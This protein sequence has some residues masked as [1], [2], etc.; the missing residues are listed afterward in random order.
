MPE[1]ISRFEDSIRTAEIKKEM[2]LATIGKATDS[3]A[4]LEDRAKR[5]TE[6]K[7]IIQTVAKDTQTNLE[8]HISNVCSIALESIFDDPYEFKL[9]YEI[10]R[11]RTEAKLTLIKDGEE[12]EPMYGA[13]GGVV[14][15]VAFALRIA[16]LLLSNNS[17]VIV[18]D[19]P[20][21]F[22]S[23][24]LQPKA[25][26]M[27]SQLSENLGIQFIMVTHNEA[28]VEQADTVIEVSQG[29]GVSRVDQEK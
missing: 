27:L 19:E 7:N 23:K 18:L 1:K 17:K 5:L 4:D 9:M 10:K 24:D 16:L 22:L 3:I 13:G 20:F 14:D 21:R 29:K 12:I 15:V 28:F 11:N 8:E 25:G 2:V 26:I 6:V